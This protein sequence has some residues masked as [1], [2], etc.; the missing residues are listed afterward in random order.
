MGL[1]PSVQKNDIN[2]IMAIISLV[3]CCIITFVYVPYCLWIFYKDRNEMYAKK[4]RPVLVI[5]LILTNVVIQLCLVLT[6]CLCTFSQIRA[7]SKRRI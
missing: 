7:I 1:A 2:Y 3:T 4:R 5:A 6:N